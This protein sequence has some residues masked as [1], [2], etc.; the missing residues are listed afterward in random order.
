MN[1]RLPS[2]LDYLSQGS[3]PSSGV[4]DSV[5][6]TVISTGNDALNVLF[7][8]ASRDR[9]SMLNDSES[10]ASER[11]SHQI[12]P[13]KTNPNTTQADIPNPS[14]EV[15]GTWESCRFVTMGWLS[16]KDA[17]LYI[18][19]YVIAFPSPLM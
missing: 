16:A 5:I 9:N 12:Q 3:P 2:N 1:G 15:L 6:R 19:L 7:E 4:A 18:D 11:V 17:V 13:L 8:A 14:P 10:P